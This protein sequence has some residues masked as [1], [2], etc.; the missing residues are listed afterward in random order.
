MDDET[1]AQLEE[2]AADYDRDYDDVAQLY[3]DK[4]TQVQEADVVGLADD[5]YPQIA[6]NT[7]VGK[8][9]QQARTGPTGEAEEVPVLAI[10]N[11][12]VFDNWGQNND[13]VMVAVGIASP[14]DTESENRP[15]GVTVFFLNES[16]GL[17]IG[18]ARDMW[19]W[20]NHLRG[21]FDME[22]LDTFTGRKRSYYRG[23]ST[24]RSRVEH[25]EFDDLP[26]EPAAVREF[27][28][29]HFVKES[30][31]L[32]DVAS[33]VPP[34]Y[35]EFGASWA[36]LRRFQGQV[37]DVFR[38]TEAECD[39]GDN[40]FGKMTLIDHTVASPD[41]LESNDDL[42]DEDDVKN[43]RQLGLQVFCEPD[44]IEYG[45]D[46]TVEVYGNLTRSDTGKHTMRACGV[47]PIIPVPYDDGQ[48]EDHDDAEQEAL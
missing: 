24:D 44:H 14:D 31:T 47:A 6:L 17:D 46:S 29:D 13:T 27:V 21:W 30:F 40:P 3:E 45:E 34:E 7:V 12:G 16:R 38:R 25:D 8:L 2:V 32:D 9:Q 37:V 22:K 18:K 43:G 19:K 39:P 41:E 5:E 42:V 15:A 33:A 35:D 1:K 48:G 23:N 26:T 11:F 36:D 20:G 10:G 4:L 28:N